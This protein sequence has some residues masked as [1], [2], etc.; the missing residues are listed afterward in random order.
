VAQ[1]PVNP[2]AQ[3]WS[4]TIPSRLWVQLNDHLFRGDHDE[5]G[6]VLLAGHAEGPRGRRLLVRELVGPS[7]DWPAAAT[8]RVSCG[9]VPRAG[10]VYQSYWF[11][12]EMSMAVDVAVQ[13]SVSGPP[14]RRLMLVQVKRVSLPAS[15]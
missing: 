15:P 14:S 10:H 7:P 1:H 8:G 2:P 6:A 4:L 13:R 12:Q 3:G 5:H 11:S 9:S